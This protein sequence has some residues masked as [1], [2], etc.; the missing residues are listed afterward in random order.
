M[1]RLKL[2][3][4][5]SLVII[6]SSGIGSSF[7]LSSPSQKNSSLAPLKNSAK[8]TSFSSKEGVFISGRQLLVHGEPFIMKGICYSPVRK[9]GNFPEDLMINNPTVKDLAVIQHDFQMMHAAGINTIRTYFPIIDSRI[10]KLLT[11][12]QLRTIVP[13]L[14]SHQTSFQNLS[15]TITLLKNHPSTLI[16]EIGNEWD[17]NFFYS[18]KMD[19][20]HPQGLGFQDS[21]KLVKNSA[22]Y[23]KLLDKRHPVSTGVSARVLKNR[24]HL[25]QLAQLDSVD[26]FGINI[27]H[28]LSFG[29]RLDQW[30]SH[31]TKPLYIGECGADA[32]NT[33]I[34]AED[35][36]SQEIATRCLITE[37]LNNLS[38]VNPKNVLIGGC[39]FEW[40]DEWWKDPNGSPLTH[41]NGGIVA[42]G[43]GPYPDYVF[44][45][46]WWG[47]V[48][49]DR[50]P[51]PAYTPLKELYL[52]NR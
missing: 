38:A 35:D 3:L 20:K 43:E 52:K 12:Y 42:P 34:N 50:H 33:L 17:I 44:N 4:L 9:G 10:L 5:V 26:L 1:K 19:L 7:P 29:N 30:A 49:I 23:I 37:I 45:E 16:W 18:K 47:I 27:Y 48:D 28:G 41:D 15:S 46:E 24:S 13:V 25:A 6:I 21:L 31:M 11:K 8:A 40:N 22:T 2:F 32:F 14:S 36:A 51:R 39:I